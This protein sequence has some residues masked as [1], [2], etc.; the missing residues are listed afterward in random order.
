MGDDVM[1]EKWIEN[2][3]GNWVWVDPDGAWATVYATN[4]G[5]GGVWNGA[6]DGRPRQLK[7]KA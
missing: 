3:N 1:T 7:G 2:S 4:N 6:A 5:W